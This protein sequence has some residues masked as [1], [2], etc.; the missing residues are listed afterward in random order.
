M[1]GDHLDDGE[2]YSDDLGRLRR[3]RKE[4]DVGGLADLT[5]DP[6]VHRHVRLRAI[7]AL[8]RPGNVTAIKPLTECATRADS[9][10]RIAAV[11]ALARLG[12]EQAVRPLVASLRDPHP[13][14][15]AWAADGL[16]RLGDPDAVPF[17]LAGLESDEWQ[18]RGASARALGKIGGGQAVAALTEAR[19]RE[20]RLRQRFFVTRALW[21]AKRK[22]AD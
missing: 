13:I 4:M 12:T 1:S 15:A 16:G 6:A 22:R 18:V 8:G 21:L 14:V 9:D 17:L 19:K 20:Q 3:L 2:K 7:R 11:L 5:Q 10:E